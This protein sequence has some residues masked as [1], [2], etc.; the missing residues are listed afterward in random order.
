MSDRA[1]NQLLDSGYECADEV[2]HTEDLELEEEEINEEIHLQEEA[3]S[4][5]AKED[6]VHYSSSSEESSHPSS[7]A[8]SAS[9]METE[10]VRRH[11]ENCFQ[12][13]NTISESTRR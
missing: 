3:P 1:V 9:S 7:S 13:T 11:V 10:A 2:L 4:P 12:L 5:S 6:E 8:P